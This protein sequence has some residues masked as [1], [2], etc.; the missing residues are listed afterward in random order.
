MIYNNNDD[1]VY[2]KYNDI[3]NSYINNYI[4][5]NSFFSDFGLFGGF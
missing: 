4:V 5:N 2:N 1:I 3:Y